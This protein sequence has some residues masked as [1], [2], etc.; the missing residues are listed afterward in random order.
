M[1]VQIITWVIHIIAE[2]SS[3]WN[4]HLLWLARKST[5]FCSGS[6]MIGPRCC[7][8]P[9]PAS[10]SLA[11]RRIP[12]CSGNNNKIAKARNRVYRGTSGRPISTA[13]NCNKKGF[14]DKNNAQCAPLFQALVALFC[15]QQEYFLPLCLCCRSRPGL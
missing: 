2:C 15:A 13:A 7:C 11:L 1:H 8:Y 10:L 3:P 5:G 14:G 9:L 12:E 6:L 4:F